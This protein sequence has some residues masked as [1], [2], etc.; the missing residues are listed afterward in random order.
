MNISI[1]APDEH[2]RRWQPT[3]S[4]PLPGMTMGPYKHDRW[5]YSSLQERGKAV[6]ALDRDSMR[7]VEGNQDLRRRLTERA[8]EP[9]EA[10]AQFPGRLTYAYERRR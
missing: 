7:V 3:R 8:R 6:E 1:T 9:D 5:R 2:N 4:A 10:K